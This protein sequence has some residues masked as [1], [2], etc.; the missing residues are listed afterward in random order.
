MD[1]PQNYFGNTV[2]CCSDYNSCKTHVHMY[3]VLAYDA[4][5]LLDLIKTIKPHGVDDVRDRQQKGYN[6]Y[7][8]MYIYNE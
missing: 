2:L 6:V 4:W 5:E 8:I 7:I 1:I 3:T